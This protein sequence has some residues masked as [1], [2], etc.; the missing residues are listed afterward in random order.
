MNG[1]G[2][3][4]GWVGGCDGWVGGHVMEGSGGATAAVESRR[5]SSLFFDTW[6]RFLFLARRLV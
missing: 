4:D 5:G 3:Y 6:L 2:G 1:S